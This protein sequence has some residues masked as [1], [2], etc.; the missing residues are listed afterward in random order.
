MPENPVT[1][2]KRVRKPR[3]KK[4]KTTNGDG[5]HGAAQAAGT[6]G[7][8]AGAALGP[9]A[10]VE[11]V[12]V[13]TAEQG[14]ELA[15]LAVQATRFGPNPGFLQGQPVELVRAALIESMPPEWRDKGAHGWIANLRDPQMLVLCLTYFAA[16]W[17]LGYVVGEDAGKKSAKK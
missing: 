15:A 2:E 12:R 7:G 16:Y 9:P 1:K 11:P 3:A 8:V 10:A 4:P 5:A 17:N 14:R 6:F 13:F